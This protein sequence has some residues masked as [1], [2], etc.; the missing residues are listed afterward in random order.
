MYVTTSS[1][2][3]LRWFIG[4]LIY[5]YSPILS[6]SVNCH[7]QKN[8]QVVVKLRFDSG[9]YSPPSKGPV[10]YKRKAP[11]QV[12]R[13]GDRLATYRRNQAKATGDHDIDYLQTQ[14]RST[15]PTHVEICVNKPFIAESPTQQL[16]RRP[17]QT[18]DSKQDLMVNPVGVKTRSQVK[19]STADTPEMHRCD[20]STETVST[21]VLDPIEPLCFNNTEH[22]A[23]LL[24]VD[25]LS[26]IDSN[27]DTDSESVYD[28]RET[29][30]D[31]DLS[32][33]EEARMPLDL[34]PDVPP[35]WWDS[36]VSDMKRDISSMFLNMDKS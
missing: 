33:S 4:D 14:S 10:A 5:T 6:L 7:D 22:D 34:P 17:D 23:S 27:A 2:H 35:V 31:A 28:K 29:D 9:H 24:S 25:G 12:K 36:M 18:T 19:A 1:C 15:S 30:A 26:C 13:D 32:D 8:G 16:N 20:I 11:S 21:S 3:K